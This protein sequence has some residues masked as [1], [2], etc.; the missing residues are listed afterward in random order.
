[1]KMGWI[2]EGPE[3]ES[4]REIKQ[5]MAVSHGLCQELSDLLR[6]LRVRSEDS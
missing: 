2:D 4:L 3:S 6:N 1:M 5:P